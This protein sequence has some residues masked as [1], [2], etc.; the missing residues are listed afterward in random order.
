MENVLL[1]TEPTVIHARQSEVGTK[2]ADRPKHKPT[3]K[4][5]AKPK[6][7]AQQTSVTKQSPGKVVPEF[8]WV[9]SSFGGS[10]SHEHYVFM[11]GT[12]AAETMPAM[13]SRFTLQTENPKMGSI[14]VAKDQRSGL[15][16]G[17][18]EGARVN[19]ANHMRA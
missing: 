12:K 2:K 4:T 13:A 17:S 19:L 18:V 1:S 14:D 9:L 11:A 15:S 5:F 3:S 10:R 7:T 16:V 8:G 6:F